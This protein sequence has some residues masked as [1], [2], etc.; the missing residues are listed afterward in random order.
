MTFTL[1]YLSSTKSP[2]DNKQCSVVFV[3]FCTTLLTQTRYN[4]PVGVGKFQ[5]ILSASK[6]QHL[7]QTKLLKEISQL[8]KQFFIMHFRSNIFIKILVAS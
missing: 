2:D 4:N 8:Q 7:I 1:T 3:L 6:V 5:K